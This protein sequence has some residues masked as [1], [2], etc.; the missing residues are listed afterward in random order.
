MGVDAAD[1]DGDG[2]E[3]LFVSHLTTES[4]T[5]YVNDGSGFFED[6]TTESGLG[7]PSL[8]YT[9]F[10]AGW[11]D[12]D[13]DGWLDLLVLSGAVRILEPLARAGDPFPLGQPNQL[14]RN[15]R[16]RVFEELS[17]EAGEVFSRLEVS[18]G[19]AIGDVDNDGD[20]DAVQLNNNGPARLLLN[21]VGA[22]AR[23]LGLRAAVA[24]GLL[25][26]TAVRLRATTAS[27]VEL[28]RRSRRDG[29]YCSSRDPR[30]LV[31]FGELG[32]PVA[33]EVIWD[34]ERR[35]R[36]VGAVPS[37]HY[38]TVYPPFS[39]RRRLGYDRSASR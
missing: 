5:L 16:G 2:D 14:F 34:A 4:N 33:V 1:F 24:D 17:G 18:R 35:S 6:R 29:S 26:S 25:P 8:P 10:G 20:P 36:W 15:R 21:R 19:L 31:G 12:F 23:W 13:S 22:S 30:I 28:W 11:L 7:G 38:L 27:G 3:D 32:P 9:S 37:A 39:G